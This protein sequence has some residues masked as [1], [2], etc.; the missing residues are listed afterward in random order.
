[1]SFSLTWG[2]V[3]RGNFSVLGKGMLSQIRVVVWYNLMF[4]ERIRSVLRVLYFAFS[5]VR[6]LLA[7]SVISFKQIVWVIL[8]NRV[9]HKLE[10][11]FTESSNYSNMFYASSALL[12]WPNTNTQFLSFLPPLL[13]LSVLL[14]CS[15][16]QRA[17]SLIYTITD[18]SPWVP[19]GSS[20]SSHN[21]SLSPK[22]QRWQR[23]E[24]WVYIRKTE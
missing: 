22:G 5:R 8:S 14:L 18:Y 15:P 21:A 20:S 4:D 12:I 17:S 19:Y 23:N 24:R 2:A 1:M 13:S 10:R 9:R 7:T 6:V 11:H 16:Y 3:K